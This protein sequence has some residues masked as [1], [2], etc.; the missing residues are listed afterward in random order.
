MVNKNEMVFAKNRVS[1]IKTVN[2]IKLL[3]NYYIELNDGG[4]TSTTTHNQQRS[5]EAQRWGR[6]LNLLHVNAINQSYMTSI[7]FSFLFLE[8]LA[9]VLLFH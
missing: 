3:R 8:T 9:I 7:F 6:G 1:I 2:Q 5:G 4:R